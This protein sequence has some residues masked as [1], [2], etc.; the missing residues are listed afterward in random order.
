M[1]HLVLFWCLAWKVYFPENRIEE[2]SVENIPW[3]NPTELVCNQIRCTATTL[4]ESQ[5]R[6]HGC[7]IKKDQLFRSNL[8]FAFPESKIVYLVLSEAYFFS[9][10]SIQG[11]PSACISWWCLRFHLS[12]CGVDSGAGRRISKYP[13]YSP[14]SPNLR[15]SP[16]S[17]NLIYSPHSQNFK[18]WPHSPNLIYSPHSPNLKY[19]THSP[20]LK[21]SPVLTYSTDSP[22]TPDLHLHIENDY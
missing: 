4:K 1:L 12:S 3:G 18:Y 7:G 6:R 8:I 19:S 15:Y 17:Q 5:H 11:S 14:H 9:L 22:K 2:V 20:N 16:H 21:Y 10:H 13:K